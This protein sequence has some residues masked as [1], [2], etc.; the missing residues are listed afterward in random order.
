MMFMTMSFRISSR[1]FLDDRGEIVEDHLPPW[2]DALGHPGQR[3]VQVIEALVDER[4]RR[5]AVLLLAER[6]RQQR[7]E[8]GAVQALGPDEPP[9]EHDP[10]GRDELEQLAFETAGLTLPDA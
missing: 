6:E 1:P 9:A 3:G 2:S 10:L 4:Q 7:V 8:R 5:G